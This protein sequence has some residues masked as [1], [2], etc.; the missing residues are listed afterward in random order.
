MATFSA[1]ALSIQPLYRAT[2]P[3]VYG[4]TILANTG[5]PYTAILTNHSSQYWLTIHVKNCLTIH[6]R[7]LPDHTRLGGTAGAYGALTPHTR[8]ARQLYCVKTKAFS[9]M[10]SLH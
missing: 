1:A 6:G 3:T 7:E 5:P 9:G 2:I 10:P 8:R 4:L